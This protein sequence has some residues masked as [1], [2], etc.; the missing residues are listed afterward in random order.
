MTFLTAPGTARRVFAVFGLIIFGF[1]V[2]FLTTTSWKTP[3][4]QINLWKLGRDFRA[5]VLSHPADSVRV[6]AFK[7]FGGLFDSAAH[8]CDYFVGEFRKSAD[9]KENIQKHYQ[10][11]GAFSVQVRFWDED[12]FWTYYPWSELYG[13]LRR[14]LDADPAEQSGLYIVFISQTGHPPYKDFRCGLNS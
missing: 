9:A 2:G 3:M 5:L 12:E 10:K 6:L 11:R 14:I 8:S 4:H 7:R 1:V 13:E